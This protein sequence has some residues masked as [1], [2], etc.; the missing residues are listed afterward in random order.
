M[1]TQ[2]A[3]EG[4]PAIVGRSL[5]LGTC[6]ERQPGRRGMQAHAQRAQSCSRSRC[7]LGHRNKRNSRAIVLCNTAPA[8]LP[9]QC[10]DASRRHAAK[11]ADHD[12][13]SQIPAL[14]GPACDRASRLSRRTAGRSR[15]PAGRLVVA[16]D[17]WRPTAGWYTPGCQAHDRC[18]GAAAGCSASELPATRRRTARMT[19]RRRSRRIR[20]TP[21]RL[22]TCDLPC[23]FANS[24]AFFA[25]SQRFNADLQ[26]AVCTDISV[27]R[28]GR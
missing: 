27:A 18:A 1:T 8:R 11:C 15:L 19:A 2:C 9:E 13:P 26:D 5:G 3:C 24:R 12:R 4:S 6:G 7:R 17:A 23:T 25:C 20:H 10:R 16:G 22:A 14:R 21:F 28:R